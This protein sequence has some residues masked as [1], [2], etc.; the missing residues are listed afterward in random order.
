MLETRKAEWRKMVANYGGADIGMCE[1]EH[2]SEALDVIEAVLD[3]LGLPAT[4]DADENWL[5]RFIEGKLF[6]AIKEA[7]KEIEES[8]HL[9]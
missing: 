6:G 7:R 2:A 4:K 9:N 3:D 1:V 8:D 5:S